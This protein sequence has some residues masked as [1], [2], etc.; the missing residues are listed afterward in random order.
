MSFAPR[1]TY[2]LPG[3]LPRSYYLGH[4]ASALAKM[5]TMLSTIDLVL[6]VR[7]FRAPHASAN[8]LLARALAGTTS[9]ARPRRRI[10]VYAKRDLGAQ[11]Q[12]G[13]RVEEELRR[14]LRAKTGAHGRG[15]RGGEGDELFFFSASGSG[16]QRRSN[17]PALLKV[18]KKHAQAAFSLTGTRILV[19][20]MP[21]VGKSTLLNA[22][23]A[24]SKVPGA[25]A[26]VAPT[27]G[28]PGVTRSVG[29]PV[30]IMEGWEVD[31]LQAAPT[32]EETAAAAAAAAGQGEHMARSEPVYVHDTPGVFVPYLP[33]GMAMLALALCGCIKEGLVPPVTLADFL[34]FHLNKH[35]PE[36]YAHLLPEGSGPTND[37]TR[38]LHGVAKRHGKLAK[39]GGVDLEST[40]VW[41][42]QKW[43]RG[44]VGRFMLE[45]VFE[46]VVEEDSE[47][48]VSVSQARK[49]EKERRRER[50]RLKRVAI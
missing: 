47:A 36:C 33:N 30:K 11:E 2:A 1:L 15:E 50:S 8:P 10:V 12:A 29:S 45:D 9:S 41:L 16:T 13:V 31:G 27:G 38:L 22:L 28:Q 4:H 18:V 26:K 42:V 25:K 17:A 32:A 24:A 34:L 37:V 40:A 43:R 5:T 3:N 46:P 49:A 14:Q 21:N 6:E 20:G 19:A 23:R 39:G 48:L 44:E 35:A 7:D